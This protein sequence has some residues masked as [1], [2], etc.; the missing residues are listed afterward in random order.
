MNFYKFTPFSFMCNL[1]YLKL[2]IDQSCE[3]FS[4]LPLNTSLFKLLLLVFVS[5]YVFDIFFKCTIS[6]N[7]NKIYVICSSG[8]AEL[9]TESL[10]PLSFYSTSFHLAYGGTPSSPNLFL[11]ISIFCSLFKINYKYDLTIQS[12]CPLFPY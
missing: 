1:P 5:F 8:S 2:F 11:S 9:N 4:V 7:T 10:S 6:G 3:S 12:S